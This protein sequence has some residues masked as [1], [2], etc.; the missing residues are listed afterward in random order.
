VLLPSGE[1]V[2]QSGYDA[3]SGFYL[4]LEQEF[5]A[6]MPT[7]EAVALLVDLYHDFPTQD[8]AGFVAYL[9]TM[10]ARN[11]IDGPTPLFAFDG[12]HPGCGKGLSVDIGSMLVEGGKAIPY[13]GFPDNTE[14]VKYL[15][16][17]ARIGSPLICF[18]NVDCLF[19]GAAIEAA[20]TTGS[21]TARLLGSSTTL[22]AAMNI[23]WAATGNGMVLG[24]D[25]P[26]RTISIQIDAPPQPHLR[27]GFK[28]PDLLGYVRDNRPLLYMAA[29]SIV[30]N[31][32][33]AGC[34]AHNE[35][36]MGSFSQWDRIIRAAVINA[37]LSDPFKPTI[38][39]EHEDPEVAL[40]YKSWIFNEPTSVGDAVRA[41]VESPSVFADLHELLKR[42][43]HDRVNHWL[44]NLFR[45]AAGV[46]MDGKTFAKTDHKSPKWY[47]I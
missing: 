44:G 8:V 10:V 7:A 32:L 28:H 27:S 6:L 3:A 1:I 26:R 40:L 5:P 9:L 43:P 13:P 23:V 31:H 22:T 34:P 42:C 19:R 29:L 11:V 2:S 18:D 17:Q 14:M 38:E 35:S 25:M 45:R 37:G 39:V 12:N 21:L 33:K 24:P 20:I 41:A 4:H 30:A 47:V 46:S 36:P 15:L 16:A